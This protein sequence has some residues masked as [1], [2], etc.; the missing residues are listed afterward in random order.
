MEEKANNKLNKLSLGIL[1]IEL[2]LA[3]IIVG[4]I[5]IITLFSG[6]ISSFIY[7]DF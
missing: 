3:A 1:A 4:M 2:A 7:I 6:D 5:I